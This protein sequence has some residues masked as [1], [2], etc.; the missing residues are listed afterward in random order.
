[1]SKL[2]ESDSRAYTVSDCAVLSRS[3]FIYNLLDTE[4]S[5]MGPDGFEFGFTKDNTG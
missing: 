4:I 3:L 5:V 1:M 2:R